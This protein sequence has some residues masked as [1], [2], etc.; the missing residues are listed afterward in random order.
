[1][2][3]IKNINI[4]TL[5]NNLIYPI[6]E[7]QL[8]DPQLNKVLDYNLDKLVNKKFKELTVIHTLGKYK[9]ETITFIGLGSSKK[10]TSKQIRD[11]A[12]LIK[13]D[14][15]ATIYLEG[16][17]T[18]HLDIHTITRAF[19]ESYLQNSYQEHKIG[20]EPKVIHEF[21]IIFSQAELEND[22]QLGKVYGEG[23]NYA[24]MLSDTPS[25]LCTILNK[26]NLEKMEAGGILS[27]NQGSNIP[28]YM[29]CLKYNNS[30][31][32][33]TAVIGK[34]LT[35]DSGGYNLKSDSYGMKYDMCGGADVLGVMQILAA[36]QAKANVY[37]IIPTT[38]NLVSDKAY[39]PQDVITTL[40]KKTVE[41][42]STDAEGRLIL[43]DAITYVQQ[44]GVKKIIDLATL[45]GACVSALGDVYTGVFSNCDEYYDEFVQA[46]QI[47]DE[48]GWRLPLD[49]EYFEKLKST[50]ADF[51]NSAGKPGGGASVA[52][53]F[54]E[55]FIEEGTQWLHLDIA[56]SADNDGTGA[57]GA[58]IRS[59]VNM[60]N[61]K[62]IVKK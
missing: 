56:G 50:S 22:I 32:P 35:F 48:K 42:V 26:S 37:G 46:L 24:R 13:L 34:G 61:L 51:K 39:K 6:Y 5:E 2:K 54:L 4:E 36:S 58:M 21:D 3:Q 8:I 47:S 55:A 15:H 18:D 31:D 44:L 10:I 28:A 33:Y 30:D 49:S 59:V 16:I 62:T 43:C 11:I 41:I 20:H 53:N 19:I 17:N 60:I 23:I 40:S 7:D 52:A 29:I 9:F 1:M 57:T 27:V 45:T 12:A 25:N 14:E 38:E